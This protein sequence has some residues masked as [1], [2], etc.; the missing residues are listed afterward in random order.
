M[1]LNEI[2]TTI[3]DKCNRNGFPEIAKEIDKNISK[4]STGTEITMSVGSFLVE[5]KNNSPE[6]NDLIGS[7]IDA[8]ADICREKGLVIK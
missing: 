7:D 6:I 3:K 1:S 2:I 5:T 4:G 8:Y